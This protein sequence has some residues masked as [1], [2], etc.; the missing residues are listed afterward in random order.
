MTT[1]YKGNREMHF[2]QDDEG[3][4]FVSREGFWHWTETTK[5]EGNRWFLEAMNNGWKRRE[6]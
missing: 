6:N 2:F 3:R 4:C 1:L 5:D